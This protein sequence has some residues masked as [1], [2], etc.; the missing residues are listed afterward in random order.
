MALVVASGVRA[1]VPDAGD[2][3]APPPP[4]GVLRVAR[5]VGE[6]QLQALISAFP[7]DGDRAR[8]AADDAFEEFAKTFAALDGPDGP[9][10]RV[11]AQAGVAPVAVGSDAYAVFAESAR[12]AAL[13]DGAFDPTAAVYEL[14]WPFKSGTVMQTPPVEDV[15]RRTPLVDHRQLAL[16][17]VAQTVMLR[18][19]GMR[20]GLADL[21]KGM[22]LDRAM[23]VMRQK[24]FGDAVIYAGGDLVV[25]G[26]KAGK[27]WMVGIQD[28]RGNTH[29][30]ALPVTGGSVFTCGDYERS[31]FERGRRYH[32]VLDPRTGMPSRG[33]RSVTVVAPTGV[34]AAGLS[35]GVFVMGPEKGMR[36]VER[37]PNVEAL[38]VD[39]RNR[40]LVTKRVAGQLKYRPP[41]DGP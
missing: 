36:L 41:T 38:M 15:E 22:A 3:P 29:F 12:L 13:T 39:D 24:G 4:P 1:Q 35:C 23:T 27:P 30:A 14:L 11:S 26:H 7:D 20:V 25:S 28:P 5:T 16:D 19:P 10:F 33:V 9:A 17:P 32:D 2:K 40:V 21:P 37:L 34:E 6:V 31:F 8:A 18:K